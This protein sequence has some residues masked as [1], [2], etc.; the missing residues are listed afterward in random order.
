MPAIFLFLPL[1][2]RL[3]ASGGGTTLPNGIQLPAE[4][5][6]RRDSLPYEPMAV[7]YL[8]APPEV[9]PIDL[10]RQLLVDD[11][12]I[13]ES[14]LARI[15]HQAKYYEGNPVL[16]PDQPWETKDGGAAAM[17]FSDGVWYDPRDRLF[18]LWYM[19]GYW[20]GLAYAYSEDGIRWTKPKLKVKPGTNIV[21]DVPRGSTTVWLDHEETLPARRFK[22]FRQRPTKPPTFDIWF[23]PDGIQWTLQDVVS[24]TGKDRSTLFRN[25]F[26]KVWVFSLKD[27]NRNGRI[28]RYHEAADILEG[29]RWSKQQAN[30]WVG[31]DCLDPQR[32]DF[33]RGAHL[34]NLDGVAYES[35][36]LGFFTIWRGQTKGGERAKPNEVLV[37]Y[38]RDGF[39]WH[40][41]DRR[42]L[43]PVSERK[44]DWNWGNVQSTGG[45][46]LIVKDE[47]YCYVSGRSGG[48]AG[49]DSGICRTGL[50]KLRRDGFVSLRADEREGTLT[51]RPVRFSGRHLFVNAKAGAVRA[52]LL[53]TNGQVIQP[54]SRANAVAFSG[55]S[56]RT[57]LEWKGAAD[58][59]AAAGR[60]VRIRFY[61]ERGD[62]YSFWVSAK[63]SGASGGYVAAGGPGLAGL[64]DEG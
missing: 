50:A 47:L 48:S 63:E 27:D 5:P 25:P 62:L 39:H 42:A 46:T 37:G 14:N 20:G 9:I 18:K 49:A 56:T 6:P 10:G 12:L 45:C 53:E 52:E 30:P 59:A 26:R 61:V 24:G 36:I 64:V 40:R 2:G 28:R 41:P 3:E 35:L 1:A 23:S 34:Y 33:R 15:H 19:A 4:W 43:I 38:S 21:L 51:T 7:P 32:D 55:D 60:P 54:Y 22:L 57:R 8:T 44:G 58:V 16:E 31:A 17:T 29:N 11:F 13:A